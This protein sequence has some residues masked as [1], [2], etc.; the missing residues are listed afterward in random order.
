[1]RNMRYIKLFE[2]YDSIKQV[3]EEVIKFVVTFDLVELSSDP[4]EQESFDD[5]D[6]A[7]KYYKTAFEYYDGKYKTNT[8]NKR[9]DEVTYNVTYEY[10]SETETKEDIE[11][12]MKEYEVIDSDTLES[13]DYK[14]NETSDNL[15]DEI[16]DWFRTKYKSRHYKYHTIDVFYNKEDY[17]TIQIRFADHT[18]NIMNNDRFQNSDYYIS[19]VVSNFDVTNNRFGVQNSFERHN[20]EYELRY[21]NNDDMF[22]MEQEIEQQI[23]EI[24]EEILDRNS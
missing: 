5:Y 21:S 8:H 20:N 6:T 15:L 2:E 1:M 10:D 18:E 7:L 3:E 11:D 4:I 19:V 22:E 9:L 14:I 16:E 17:K 24:K 23:E 13:K 12:Y